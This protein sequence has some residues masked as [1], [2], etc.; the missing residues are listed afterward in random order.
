MLSRFLII[1]GVM[2][3]IIG[4]PKNVI[5]EEGAFRRALLVGITKYPNVGKE[6]ELNG[7]NND[8]DIISKV[9]LNKFGFNNQDITI[10][11]EKL[12]QTNTNKLPTKKNIEE[13][14]IKL[15]T[16]VREGEQVVVFLAGHGTELPTPTGPAGHFL[17]RDV[18]PW[19]GEKGNGLVPNAIPGTE[20]GAWLRPIAEKKA[21]LWLIVDA[22]FTGRMVRGGITK[23]RQLPTDPKI[24]GG[25]QV[26]L[27]AFHQEARRGGSVP[28]SLIPLSDYDNVA[29]MYACNPDEVTLEEPAVSG[30]QNSP[31]IGLFTRSL[32]EVLLNSSSIPTYRE[33]NGRIMKLIA[34]S[35]RN[36]PTPLVEGGAINKQVL[37]QKVIQR[38]SF[39]VS[40]TDEGNLSINAGFLHGVTI[41]SLLSVFP[42]PGQGENQCGF[43]KIIRID[44]ANSIGE[45]YAD[46]FGQIAKKAIL[47]NGRAEL[48]RLD[49]SKN[50]IHIGIDPINSNGQNVPVD[51]LIQLKKTLLDIVNPINQSFRFTESL[52]EAHLVLKFNEKDV[53]FTD[54]NF[55]VSKIKHPLPIQTFHKIDENLYPWLKTKLEQIGR[56]KALLRLHADAA[57]DPSI[58]LRV[59]LLKLAAKNSTTGN[60]IE[61]AIKT[62]HVQ[63]FV[64]FDLKNESDVPIDVT[65]LYIDSNFEIDAIFPVKGEKNRI[66]PGEALRPLPVC[67]ISNKTLGYEYVVVIAVENKGAD[68]IEFTALS[69][70]RRSVATSQKQIETPLGRLLSDSVLGGGTKRSVN[71]NLFRSYAVDLLP[72]EILP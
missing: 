67:K 51:L 3:L 24:K 43:L 55:S 27:E 17:P 32:G 20:I 30:D 15:A 29:C 36:A 2:I 54:L 19:K 14:F 42:P 9:L 70:F 40:E 53:C 6:F 50:L 45:P 31:I 41:G 11:S 34:A 63:D 26:P 48:F 66:P 49:Y 12:G 69:P 8:V 1:I 21:N 18:F 64:A 71:Q 38:N 61:E 22:C 5:A 65:I 37:R 4:F 52:A 72:L 58:R 28:K 13:A 68:L 62:V 25:L 16:G 60:K 7:G 10:L 23:V 35:G 56:A 39:I 44:P 33:L 47:I 57:R 59:N 46:E